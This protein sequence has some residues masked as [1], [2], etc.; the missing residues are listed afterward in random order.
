MNR[1]KNQIYHY[2]LS[3][4]EAVLREW[5]NTCLIDPYGDHSYQT[6]RENCEEQEAEIKSLL[7]LETLCKAGRNP[8]TDYTDLHLWFIVAGGENPYIVSFNYFEEF[9]NKMDNLDAFLQFV[10]EKPQL[11][12]DLVEIAER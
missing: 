3:F 6:I 8:K 12:E 10:Q 2:I 4:P 5:Y 11:L 9:L 1:T 7:S